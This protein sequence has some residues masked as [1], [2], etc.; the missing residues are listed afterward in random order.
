MYKRKN[1]KLNLYALLISLFLFVSCG[2]KDKPHVI[3]LSEDEG[4][5]QHGHVTQSADGHIHGSHV[6][7]PAA[8][9]T[10]T[11]VQKEIMQYENVIKNLDGEV[12]DVSRY[13]LSANGLNQF[14]KDSGVV[15]FPAYE[16]TVPG[17]SAKASSCGLTELLPP[18]TCWY[19]TA[20]LLLTAEQI[21]S[22]IGSPFKISS[23][24][25]PKCYN[26]KI[27]GAKKSDHLEASAMD[28][29]F[30]NDANIRNKIQTYV[31]DKMWKSDI[32]GLGEEN[33]SFGLGKS[34]LHIGLNS[35]RGRRYWIYD[36]YLDSNS[37]PTQC[38]TKKFGTQ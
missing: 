24:Y 31:C 36:S 32:L 4:A 15:N 30:N 10:A 35:P 8:S 18:K 25:R 1:Q 33:I 22:A 12:Q 26:E 14:L 17:S 3:Y 29:T 5:N 9:C 6:L 13:E 11:T 37:M 16:F 23:L 34:L 21:R 2:A 27:S 28:I 20:S 7:T 38:W 19:R